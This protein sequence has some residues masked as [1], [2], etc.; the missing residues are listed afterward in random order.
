MISIEFF[1]DELTRIFDI[2]ISPGG[3]YH[4]VATAIVMYLHRLM[5]LI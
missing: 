5:P 2:L 3:K 4:L 1:K